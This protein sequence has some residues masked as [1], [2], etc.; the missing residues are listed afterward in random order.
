MTEFNVSKYNSF[1]KRSLCHKDTM[2]FRSF[3]AK[4]ECFH[5]TIILAGLGGY[6][7]IFKM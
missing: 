4:W 3:A 7:F 2:R 1:E 6:L 5:A